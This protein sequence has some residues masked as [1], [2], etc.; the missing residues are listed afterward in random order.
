M[1]ATVEKPVEKKQ[2]IQEVEGE[3]Y[4]PSCTRTVV[5]TLLVAGRRAKSK[6]GQKCPRC[7]ASLDAGFV[8]GAR[9]AA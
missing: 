4:C 5:A 9:R 6:L 7:S 1:I 3:V 2:V 8:I